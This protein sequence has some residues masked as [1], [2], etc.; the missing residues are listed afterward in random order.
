MI[1]RKWFVNKWIVAVA[2]VVLVAAAVLV[3]RRLLNAEAE[4]TLGPAQPTFGT[5]GQSCAPSP[6]DGRSC[7]IGGVEVVAIPA[8]S[9]RWAT[10]HPSRTPTN[11]QSMP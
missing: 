9:S 7:V 3:G 8:A 10:T 6:G 2:L 4:Q 1:G 11:S 5:E